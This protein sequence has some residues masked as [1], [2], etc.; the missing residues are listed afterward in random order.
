MSFANSSSLQL[1]YIQESTF[2][3]TP[4]AGNPAQ[5]RVV[6]EGFDY[7]ISKEVSKEINDTRTVS[8]AAIIGAAAPG[9]FSAEMSYREYDPFLA[10]VLQSSFVAHGAD[11]VS[12]TTSVVTFATG[13]LTA[14]VATSGAN[15]WANLQCG[16]WFRVTATGDANDGKILRVHPSTVPTT[17][18]IT[19]DTNT[20]ATA[21]ASVAGCKIAT[22]RLTHGSTQP[23]FTVERASTDIAQFFSFKGQTVSKLTLGLATSGITACGFEFVGKDAARGVTTMMPGTPVASQNFDVH[24]HVS[25]SVSQLWEGGSPVAGTF[26]KKIDMSFDNA[27]RSRDALGVL[28]AA[29]IGS[30]T[31]NLTGSMSV[32]F[33]DGALFDKYKNNTK[34]SLVFSTLDAAG[35]GYIITIPAISI[36]DYKSNGS[37]KDQDMMV[38]IQFTALRDQSNAIA[39][40]RK[41]VFID[42]VGAVQGV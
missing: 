32:Y 7:K 6:S 13:T 20:P 9:S 29:S 24:S 3:V 1:S 30:G 21:S 35:N 23:S 19:L 39:A 11:G 27:L 2:G 41:A 22:S 26:V 4:Q 28:G 18:V 40:L 17:T 8:S 34:S 33:S 5:L 10:A 37:G 14:S 38:D 36:M 16:Q 12:T 15:S 25:G 42:R 31:I